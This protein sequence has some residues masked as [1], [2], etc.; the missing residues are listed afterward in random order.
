MS[1]FLPDDFLLEGPLARRLY[2]EHAAHQPIID[3]HCHLSPRDLADDRRFENVTRLWLE[4]DHYKW[5]AMRACGVDEA[6]ITG[7]ASDRAKFDAWAAVVP[8]LVG[9]P[10]YDWT[11]M[12]LARPL[13]IGDVALSPALADRVWNEVNERLASP[14]FS[15][16]GLVRQAGVRVICTTDDPVDDLDAHRRLAAD[17]TFG[18]AVLPTFRPDRV[19]GVGDPPTW[20]S[21][22][23]RLQGVTGHAIDALDDLLGALRERAYAFREVGC[24]L[25]DHGLERLPVPPEGAAPAKDSFKRLRGGERLAAGDAERLRA[26]ILHALGCLYHE[27]GWAQQLHLGPLRDTNTRRRLALG[28]DAGTDSIGDFE[29]ARGLAAYLDGLDAKAMLPRTI[30]YNLNPRDNELFATMAGN[31]QQGPVRGHIQYGAA[32]WFLDQADGIRKQLGTLATMGVLSTFLGMLTDSRSFL[33]YSRHDYYRRVLCSWMGGEVER[34][35]WVVDERALGLLVERLC[36]T[37]ARDWFG[38]AE[39]PG[40]GV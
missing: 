8:D 7:S 19:L 40:N 12:E 18:V 17:A 11:H 6:L 34:G 16:R 4:G 24:R 38:F 25:S 13:G 9:S 3:Y 5:R 27:L 30:L 29:Q 20:N 14:G 35:R 26:D 10:L 31:F 2:R 1:P 23:D 15:A 39:N 22:V 32:W 21:Y 33:S 28:G 36:H 37:N